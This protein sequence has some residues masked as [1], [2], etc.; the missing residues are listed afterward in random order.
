MG[1]TEPAAPG[2]VRLN[3]ILLFAAFRVLNADIAQYGSIY[4]VFN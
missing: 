4:F 1:I 2:A 3:S